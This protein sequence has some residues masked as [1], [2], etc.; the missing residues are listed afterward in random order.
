[1]CKLNLIKKKHHVN[2]NWGIS[3]KVT[4]Q[5]CSKMSR[6]KRFLRSLR[7]KETKIMWDWNAVSESKK[8]SWTK[9]FFFFSYEGHLVQKLV[10][11][12]GTENYIILFYNF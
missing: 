7:L 5:Y 8:G 6:R 4:G 1:M 11:L 2:I 12:N 9:Y 10:K 3:D